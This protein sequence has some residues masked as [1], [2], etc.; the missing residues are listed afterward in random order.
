LPLTDYKIII[1]RSYLKN[2]C[3]EYTCLWKLVEEF[4]LTHIPERSSVWGFRDHFH[5]SLDEGIDPKF[6]FNT[7]R[8]IVVPV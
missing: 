8:I 2:L 5:L 6:S 7:N 1:L 3:S 4:L